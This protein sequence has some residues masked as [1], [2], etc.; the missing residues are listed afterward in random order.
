MTF[1]VFASG[2]VLNASDMN[3]VGL[4]KL[5]E[6]NFTTVASVSLNNVFTSDYDNYRILIRVTASTGAGTDN[7]FTMRLRAAG[8]DSS[9]NYVHQR[10]GAQGATTFAGANTSGTDDWFGGFAAVNATMYYSQTIDIFGP[11]LAAPTVA[12]AY[13]CELD[14]TATSVQ[15]FAMRHTASTSYDG[16]TFFTNQTNMTG[17]VWVYGYR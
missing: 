4:W 9:A 5:S 8:T 7:T 10:F 15:V 3:A 13:T 12:S 14:S 16:F 11:Q 6:T 17:T 1:P 2:D